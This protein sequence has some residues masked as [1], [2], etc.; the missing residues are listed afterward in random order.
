MY[1]VTKQYYDATASEEKVGYFR[2]SL[3]TAIAENKACDCAAIP[4]AQ[5]ADTLALAKETTV[6]ETN[7]DAIIKM[8]PDHMERFLDQVYLAGL[9]TGMYAAKYD[10][11]SVLEDNPFDASWLEAEAEKA[12][13][14]GF[15]DDGDEY[16]L[17]AL[18]EA[19][20][21][22]AG[23]KADEEKKMLSE[24]KVIEAKAL[25]DHMLWLRFNTGEEKLFDFKPLL[26]YPAF[27][28]LVD[29][30][31]FNNVSLDQGVTIWNN[32]D[33]DIAPSYLYNSSTGDSNY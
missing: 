29:P 30:E 33:I 20:L 4:E 10:D 25:P 12:T 8:Q 24:I 13:A 32:G 28:P 21:R 19:V 18:T 17:S 1:E 11:D 16:M 14:V 2:N 26:T 22:S 27:A 15:A 23:I 9:N 31:V 5:R 3:E 7:Y 6:A